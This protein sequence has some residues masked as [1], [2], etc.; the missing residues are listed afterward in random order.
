[1]CNCDKSVS[2]LLKNCEKICAKANYDVNKKG[3]TDN[4]W[5]FDTSVSINKHG[6]NILSAQFDYVNNGKSN[7]QQFLLEKYQLSCYD[8]SIENKQG[9][10]IW[11]ALY[12]DGGSGGVVT[13][14]IQRF[15]VLG[16]SGIFKNISSVIIDFRDS[17]RK[18]YFIEKN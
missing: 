12:P 5:T 3:I 4:I 18:V 11:T 17:I 9:E 8:R 6:Y 1:M 10:I 14:S 7:A 15:T 16:K 2:D 13:P